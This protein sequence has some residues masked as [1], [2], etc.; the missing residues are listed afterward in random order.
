MIDTKETLIKTKKE[1]SDHV[2]TKDISGFRR[3]LKDAVFPNNT[4]DESDD[5]FGHSTH[6]NNADH[7]QNTRRYPLRSRQSP[8][9]YGTA[10]E[11]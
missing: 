7:N 3:I 6:D 10:F 5:D 11:H 8:C 2:V 1:N 4:A 9:L